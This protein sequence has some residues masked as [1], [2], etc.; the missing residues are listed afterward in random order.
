MD[1]KIAA[2]GL[3]LA[4][5]S[6]RARADEAVGGNPGNRHTL[7]ELIA[8]ARQ[9]ST[10]VAYAQSQVEVRR[11]QKWEALSNWF[12]TGEVTFGMSPSAQV[13]CLDENGL[14]STLNCVST[15]NPSTGRAI[16]V[17]GFS[18]ISGLAGE[19]ALRF[20]QPVYTFGKIEHGTRA[21]EH[22][23]E[24]DQHRVD[25]ARDEVS[26]RVAQAY[27]GL[28][29]ARTATVTTTEARDELAS[30]VKKIEDD[31]DAQKPK[32]NFNINDLQRLKVALAQVDIGVADLERSAGIASR[33]LE[34]VTG[35]PADVDEAELDVVEIVDRPIEFY[36]DAALQNRP[37]LRALA[38]GIRA[39]H[40][41]SK[42]QF[43]QLLPDL[44]LVGGV[45][46]RFAN[47]VDD[48]ANAFMTHPNG[49]FGFSLALGLRQP[50]DLVQRHARFRR[51]RADA[52]VIVAQRKAAETL[53]A[54]EIAEAYGNLAEA[55]KRLGLVDKAQ[56]IAQGW[57]SA[58][59]QN[60]DL[61]TAEPR[62][63]VDAARSYYD[64]R[65]RYYQTIYDVNLRVAQLRKAAGLPIAGEEK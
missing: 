62:D 63:L 40:E 35:G 19:F 59:R 13:R 23:I 9:R 15:T 60:I 56:H 33:G 61:G 30:W 10:P 4:A 47:G 2:F 26:L 12:P 6:T 42:L 29:T 39:F 8:M 25:V 36:Q 16:G 34:L 28:K 51:A 11:A 41:L 55:R 3:A 65:V 24:A 22:G 17:P 54:F 18:D 1:L 37:E 52:D 49:G 50:L 48:P 44:A 31:L 46:Y 64:L 27:W 7:P 58:V 32:Y 20:T 21:A 43:S 14:P 38:S 57:L 45:N 53:Y 5:V